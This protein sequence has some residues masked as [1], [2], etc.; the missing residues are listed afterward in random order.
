MTYTSASEQQQKAHR[1]PSS[2]YSVR[3]PFWHFSGGQV[4]VDF[5]LRVRSAEKRQTNFSERHPRYTLSR[6]TSVKRREPDKQVGR[7][8]K[9]VMSMIED[10]TRNRRGWWSSVLSCSVREPPTWHG[11]ASEQATGQCR[12][13]LTD[14]QVIYTVNKQRGVLRHEKI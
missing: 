8:I 10:G 5:L 13:P 2:L 1:R 9:T 12:I 7:V 11:G 6:L 4:H 14:F 3:W